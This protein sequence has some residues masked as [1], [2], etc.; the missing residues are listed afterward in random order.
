MVDSKY[1]HISR[2][3]NVYAEKRIKRACETLGEEVLKKL[4]LFT[5][6]LRGAQSADIAEIVQM[7]LDTVNGLIKRVYQNG[8][9]AFEDHRKKTS[10]FLPPRDHIPE[11]DLF[12]IK[13]NLED[14]VISLNHGQLRIPRRDDLLCR[15]ILLIF[16]NNGLLSEEDVSKALGLSKER[17][18]KLKA[19]LKH[20]GSDSLI[21][22]HKGQQKDY[23]TPPEV[24]RELLEQYILNLRDGKSVSPSVLKRE[25]E[26]RDIKCPGVRTIA[27]HLRKLG[28]EKLDWL[29][30]NS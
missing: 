29:K 3:S 5:D 20:H 11:P 2:Y 16:V 23:K 26:S 15:S 12:E 21:N 7:P 17:I 10:S 19:Q 22:R 1:L 24:K 14:L 9:P 28:L 4:L 18:R 8:L 27:S 6:H 30:K 25:M 13:I